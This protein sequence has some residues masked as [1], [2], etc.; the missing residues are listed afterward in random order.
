MEFF[1]SPASVVGVGVVALCA[2]HLLRTLCLQEVQP[3]R[4]PQ[5]SV[6][7]PAIPDAAFLGIITIPMFKKKIRLIS[8]T[9]NTFC[10]APPPPRNFPL[11]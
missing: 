11:A 6:F 9:E 2:S 3:Y 5:V 7:S 1:L 8:C 4:H 10:D